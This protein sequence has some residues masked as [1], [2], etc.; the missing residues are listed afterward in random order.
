MKAFDIPAVLFAEIAE[1]FK[2]LR[3]RQG[4]TLKDGYREIDCVFLPADEALVSLVIDPVNAVAYLLLFP[5]KGI[6]PKQ[7]NV[8]SK[9]VFEMRAGYHQEVGSWEAGK[10]AKMVEVVGFENKPYQVHT[11]LKALGIIG[12]LILR[13]NELRCAPGYEPRTRWQCEID[14]TGDYTKR[15]R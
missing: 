11:E 7:V 10:G 13:T 15:P 5:A 9:A 4:L 3:G 2:G 1:K 12:F 8:T 14:P 6:S